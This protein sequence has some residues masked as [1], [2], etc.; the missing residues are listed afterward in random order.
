MFFHRMNCFF[1]S[2][3]VP[4]VLYCFVFSVVGV[5]QREWC[6]RGLYDGGGEIFIGVGSAHVMS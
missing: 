1:F 2:F 5:W 4:T 6:E 3:F